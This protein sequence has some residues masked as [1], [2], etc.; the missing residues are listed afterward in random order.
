MPYKDRKEYVRQW[1]IEYRRRHREQGLCIS[2][3]QEVTSG[4]IRCLEH[5]I[6][7]NLI[8]RRSY[9]NHKEQGLCP[10]CGGKSI[11]GESGCGI[12]LNK[13]RIRSRKYYQQNRE[14]HNER[15]RKCHQF[16]LDNGGC[17]NCG[18]P[19][20]EGESKYCFACM[21]KWHTSIIKGVLK[22]EIAD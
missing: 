5:E 16:Y 6:K 19:L 20:I 10:S 21:A 12:C 11:Q 13:E 14:L 3:N 1:H 2:C 15:V 8:D 22:Y 7:Q 17:F 18:A 9:Q 4:H